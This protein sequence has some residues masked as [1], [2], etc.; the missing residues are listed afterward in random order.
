MADIIQPRVLKGFRDFLPGSE[1]ARKALVARLEKTFGSFGFV[2]I[3]TPVLEYA[4]IL[5]GKGGGETD[6]QVYRFTDH[7]GREVAMRFDL[8]VPFA[9]FMAEHVEE[10]YLPFRRF[11]VAKVWRGENTQRGRYREFMQCDFDIVG[12]DSAMADADIVLVI[13]AAMRSLGVGAF[14]I[15]INHRGI[16]NRFLAK[17]GAGEKSQSALRI[18]DKIDKIGAGEVG[19]QLGAELGEKSAALILEFIRRED[20]ALATLARMESMAGGIAAD[21]ERVRSVLSAVAASGAKARVVLDPSITRGL[22]YYTGMVFE[23]TLDALPEIGSVCSGGR[24]DELASLYTARKLPGVGA[25]VGLDR[26]MAALEALGTPALSER[27]SSVLVLNLDESLGGMYQRIASD[28][29]ALGLSVELYPEQRKLA[30]Q[31]GYAE[32]KGIR[33]AI[34]LGREEME[35]NVLGVK[36]LA[37]R[38]ITETAD[39]EAAFALIAASARGAGS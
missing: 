39:A 34:V 30:Q 8:T 13:D 27:D 25:S 14:A 35:K 12:V 37:T 26:L 9:R 11:H 3:D 17:I 36:D 23:T 31:F 32:K 24:Y 1:T 33:F 2:P 28:L 15:R 6:K 22:D 29:R 20:S 5:L 21:S 38:R 10:L 19:R 18:V 4:E 16:F 7:G